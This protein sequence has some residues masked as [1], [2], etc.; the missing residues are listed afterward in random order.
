MVNYSR[1][2]R[3]IPDHRDFSIAILGTVAMV[4][5][6]FGRQPSRLEPAGSGP[7]LRLAYMPN[8]THAP[9]V[10][11]MANGT[12]SQKVTGF[13]V[14]PKLFNA[15][16]ESM[17]ALLA[18]EVDVAYV[19]PSPAI[20][21][22]LKTNGRAL[23]VI[24]GV[25]SGGASLMVQ[26]TSGIRKVA[27]LDGNRVAVPGLGGTQDV[28]L[29]HFLAANG[30][31]PKEQRGTVEIVPVKNPDILT[32]FKQ[33]QIDAA[34]VPEPWA[35]RLEKEAGA[36]RALDERDLWPGHRFTTTVLV[37]RRDFAEE[38]PKTVEQLLSANRTL[39]AWTAAHPAEAARQ[40]N[41]ELGRLSGKELPTEVIAEAWKRLD[42][43]PKLDA[44]SF[45][46]FAQA[47]RD[48][49]YATGAKVDLNGLLGAAR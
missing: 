10:L 26:G 9:A 48:A 44:N 6:A 40:V 20:N 35:T 34:W 18:K 41:A 16:P 38:N 30:H 31:R 45:V 49:G 25:C 22:Y 42:F 1:G 27:D 36:R 2:S 4:A 13:R 33:K 37:V 19:G 17:E 15:G 29:R 46:V 28:S 47:A 7:E 8:L 12:F 43:D 32:L 21:T 5:V 11:G 23:Q 39:I 3:L 14:V 24:A